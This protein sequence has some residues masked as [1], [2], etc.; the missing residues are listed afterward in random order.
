[1]RYGDYDAG[2]IKSGGWGN[3]PIEPQKKDFSFPKNYKEFMDNIPGKNFQTQE[4]IIKS[5]IEGKFDL[6]Y[7]P[8]PDTT[9]KTKPQTSNNKVLDLINNANKL[10]MAQLKEL[11]STTDLDL[12]NSSVV[13][14]NFNSDN[15]QAN[16]QLQ[17]TYTLEAT[18]E[19]MSDVL[20]MDVNDFTPVQS[21]DG[22]WALKSNKQTPE[23]HDIYHKM[24]V[25]KD[26]NAV[27]VTT[28]IR[29]SENKN[30]KN[31]SDNEN[32][33]VTTYM[34]KIKS[35][36]PDEYKSDI[37]K[38]YKDVD[39]ARN[40][41]LYQQR[42]LSK[43]KN[44]G[45]SDAEIKKQEEKINDAKNNIDVINASINSQKNV[46]IE[47][48]GRFAGAKE[49]KQSDI[50]E[51][52]EPPSVPAPKINT[53]T[54]KVNDNNI[55]DNEISP[56][57]TSQSK[58]QNQ[59]DIKDFDNRLKNASSKSLIRHFK[60][61]REK[62]I[63]A[64]NNQLEKLGFDKTKI[65]QFTKLDAPKI[66]Y[67][68]KLWQENPRAAQKDYETR[69]NNALENYK[70]LQTTTKEEFQ[71]SVE[72]LGLTGN[73]ARVFTELNLSISSFNPM[74]SRQIPE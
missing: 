71:K 64:F 42:E 43:L 72:E 53:D 35:V 11:Q 56:E 18:K 19:Y 52:A 22:T 10:N 27:F 39:N 38:T 30:P 1:M 26:N 55:K 73:I 6:D 46:G 21:E 68:E 32:Y 44:N 29:N 14:Y 54:N 40:D 59:N 28:V 12:V 25:D 36:N 3:N 61:N 60:G 65:P 70:N 16:T 24:G 33:D 57:N 62:A 13:N 8:N 5:Y 17:S 50:E 51:N 9:A 7:T 58:Q 45:A 20:N 41:L 23:G 49:V 31:K 63:E 74:E 48:F 47:V 69:Y 2:Q 34:N 66:T 67:D 4:D 37:A 15:Q